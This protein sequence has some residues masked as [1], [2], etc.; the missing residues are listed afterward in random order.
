MVCGQVD[1]VRLTVKICWFAQ[2]VPELLRSNLGERFPKILAPTCGKNLYVEYEDVYRCANWYGPPPSPRWVGVP[3]TWPF[4]VSWAMRTAPF[5]ARTSFIEMAHETC[6]RPA[7]IL[8]PGLTTVNWPHL[9]DHRQLQQLRHVDSAHCVIFY[10]LWTSRRSAKSPGFH[11][12]D[13][14]SQT[15]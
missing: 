13:H 5:S 7:P 14:E 1:H 10:G 12:S 6:C 4:L 11:C 15:W 9:S 3:G 8:Q 2:T